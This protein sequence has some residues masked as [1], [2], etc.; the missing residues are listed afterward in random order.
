MMQRKYSLLNIPLALA[1][2]ATFLSVFL[3]ERGILQATGGV[4]MYPLDDPFIHMQ[5]ARNLALNQTWGINPGEFA[6][7]SSSLFYTVLL[8][9]L[10]KLFSVQ[11]LIPFLINCLAGILLLASLDKWLDKQGMGQTARAVVLLLLVLLTP[12]PVLII[13]GM[14]HVLQCLFIFLFL[15]GFSAWLEADVKGG[16]TGKFPLSL[17]GYALLVTAVR[18]EGLFLI[19]FACLLL[20]C[21]RKWALAFTLGGIAI[22]PVILF[23]LWSI[24]HGSY[25]LPNSVLVKSEGIPFSFTGIIGYFNNI[26]INKLTVVKTQFRAVGTPPPGISLLAAQRLLLLIPL[27]Y[28]LFRDQIRKKPAYSYML[29]LLGGCTVLHLSL[30]ATGWFYR[31]EAYLVLCTFVILFVLLYNFTRSF[32]WSGGRRRENDPETGHRSGL[33]D[34]RERSLPA[35]LFTVLLFFALFFPFL[36]RSAAAFTNARQACVNIYQQQYQMGQFLKKYYDTATVAANDIGAISYYSRIRT[37]DLWGLGSMEIA[38][39][40]KGKY[41][42]PSFLDSL[43]RRDQVKL[44]I[45][46]DEWFDPELIHRW[47][48]VAT[49]QIHDNVIT[50]GET[51]SFYVI[52]P[53]DG[54]ELKAKLEDFEKSLPSGIGVMY[55]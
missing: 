48:K 33:P 4:F 55:L 25:F 1:L 16:K 13:S 23:G 51:V 17:F 14:E 54:P 43:V 37:V 5:I 10:F 28:L 30:A 52:D 20:A 45:I 42:T 34:E 49:W 41:W 29:I 24:A 50:G 46:Y 39:S 8:S 27:G 44:A 31:Y 11:V 6:S 15:T 40:K 47:K 36:L 2:L 3:I 35:C 18:Y 53:K 32:T 38:K 19:A 9:V 21:Y 12:L 26:L 7:A 22:L